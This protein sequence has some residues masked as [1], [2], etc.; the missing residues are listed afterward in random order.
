VKGSLNHLELHTGNPDATMPFYKDMLS[1]LGWK[2]VAEFPAGLGMSDGN[3]SIWW[4]HTPDDLKTSTFNRDA[5]GISH[6]GIHLASRADVDEF[7]TGYMKD[8]GIEPVL[9]TPR[10]RDDFGPSYY[11][12]MFEDPEGLLIEVFTA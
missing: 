2:V 3:A 10:A 9:E 6:I 4:F 8:H 7:H 11:Q 5:T 1:F 12:V